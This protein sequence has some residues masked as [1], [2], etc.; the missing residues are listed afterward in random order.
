MISGV[1]LRDPR[2]FPASF[3]ND[4]VG[5][6]DRNDRP[7]MVK[8]GEKPYTFIRNMLASLYTEDINKK[9]HLSNPKASAVYQKWSVSTTQDHIVT[10]LN[11]AKSLAEYNT[12]AIV[13]TVEVVSS[14][15]EGVPGFIFLGFILPQHLFI[16]WGLISCI[17]IFGHPQSRASPHAYPHLGLRPHPHF[18]L[19]SHAQ[20]CV[21]FISKCMEIF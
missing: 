5:S 1:F 18:R 7:G 2:I 6:G 19:Y 4:P 3:L 16:Y 12:T 14:I 11:Q 17:K 10:K 20:Y 21:R 13:V 15:D 8:F 9:K